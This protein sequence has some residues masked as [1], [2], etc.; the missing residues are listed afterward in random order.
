L[1]TATVRKIARG[2]PF[3]LNVAAPVT[4][5]L[6]LILTFALV[7]ANGFFVATEF[8]ITRMRPAQVTDLESQGR[9]AA[10]SVR[11][12][13]DRIDA[14]L[15]ACQLGI[16]MA[17][18]GLGVVGERVFHDLIEPLLGEQARIASVGLAGAAAFLIIT[19]LHVVVGELAPKSLAIA[20]TEPVSLAVATPMRVFYSLTK[21][22]VDLFNGMGN[23]LLKPFGIP[24]ASEAGHAPASE[25]ELRTLVRQS[26]QEGL[27]DPHEHVFA[28]NV[29]S[30]GDRRTREVMVPRPDVKVVSADQT[31]A[32]AAQRSRATGHRRFPVVEPDGGLDAVVGLLH[33]KDVLSEALESREVELRALARPLPRVSGAIALDELLRKL[34]RELNHMALVV[35]EHGTAI[36]IVTLEDVLEEIVGEIEDEFDPSDAELVHRDGDSVVIQGEAPLRLVEEELG[37]APIGGREATIGGHIIEAIGRLP[38]QGELV[39]VDGRSLEVT[40]VGEARVEELRTEPLSQDGEGRDQGGSGGERT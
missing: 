36:G 28:E 25:A 37:L 29:F 30:F 22:V 21:P 11:H 5:A 24:P 33:V 27:I 6:E 18:L 1:A 34:R 13:V 38:H 12:A 10:G 7:A 40:R 14:Y 17:S 26:S 20:R 32:D 2:G 19:L 9:A 4:V 31:P 35:D 3:S 8:A 23:L 15:A 16:T 39:Q